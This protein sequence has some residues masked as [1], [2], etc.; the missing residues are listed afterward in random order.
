LYKPF[1]TVRNLKKGFAGEGS[2]RG[3]T[4]RTFKGFVEFFILFLR[5]WILLENSGTFFGGSV[6]YLFR[7]ECTAFERESKISSFVYAEILIQPVDYFKAIV[8]KISN[9]YNDNRGGKIFKII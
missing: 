6:K 5:L 4:G 1:S 8:T 2:S 9:C 3:Y 7:S